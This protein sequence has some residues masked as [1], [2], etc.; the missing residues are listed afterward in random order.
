[1]GHSL[2]VSSASEKS[3]YLIAFDQLASSSGGVVILLVE[4]GCGN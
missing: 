4:S 1:M 3:C 2:L